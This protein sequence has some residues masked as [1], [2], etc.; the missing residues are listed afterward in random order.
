MP[1]VTVQMAGRDVEVEHR[2]AG[3]ITRVLVEA[4]DVE[5]E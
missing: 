4:L 2:L 1:I 5:P 3:E